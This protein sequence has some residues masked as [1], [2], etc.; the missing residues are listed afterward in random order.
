MV[1]DASLHGLLT[2]N[3]SDGLDTYRE[4][5]LWLS[6]YNDG[7]LHYSLGGRMPRVAC[8][9]LSVSLARQGKKGALA[10]FAKG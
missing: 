3:N 4:M 10:H 5:G 9:G 1:D 8:E 7:W 2:A 6:L